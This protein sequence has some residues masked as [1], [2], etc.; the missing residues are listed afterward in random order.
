MKTKLLFLG[1]DTTTRYAVE[2]ARSKGVYTIITD[3]N[4]PEQAP[5]KR[6]ADEY[7]MINV[8]DIDTLEA[9]CREEQVTAVFAGNHEFCLDMTKELAQRLGLPFCASDL[10]WA[11]T[12]DKALFKEYCIQAGLDVPKRY[13]LQWPITEEMLDRID[14]PVIVKPVDA[15]ASRGITV[16]HSRE[17]LKDAYEYAL[18]FS[19]SG[20]I[21]VE[22]YI[23]GEFVAAHF[24]VHDGKT[25][26][27][28]VNFN[29]MTTAGATSMESGFAAVKHKRYTQFIQDNLMDRFDK[30]IK[31]MDINHGPVMIQGIPYNGRFYVFEMGS[32][33][34]GIGDFTLGKPLFGFSLVEAMVDF[35]LGRTYPY[36]GQ[37][38]LNTNKNR[39]GII[40]LIRANPG[41]VSRVDKG[42]LSSVKGV[43]VVLERFRV[44]DEI[45][46]TRN[47]T[48]FA[49]FLSIVNESLTETIETIKQINEKLL[50][51]DENGNNLLIPFTRFDALSEILC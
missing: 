48:Q 11:C 36:A 29:V 17:N 37:S 4:T 24:Y 7:W 39:V 20:N 26:L 50:L 44:G 15:C 19:D 1:I 3:Y 49:Y 2:Y 32:R 6:L 27:T 30:L 23:E 46:E 33:L 21:I 9:K 43:D 12:R 41:V 34:D 25:Y 28:N 14:L 8:A 16:C 35:A 31:S 38:Y 13:E 51:L 22:D 42:V 18:Q 45:R 10:S 40:L 5:L 47:M